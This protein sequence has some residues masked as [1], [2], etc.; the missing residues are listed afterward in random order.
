MSGIPGQEDLA[1]QAIPLWTEARLLQLLTERITAVND[2]PDNPSAHYALLTHVRTGAGFDQQEIDAITVD[3]WPAGG[4]PMT[5]YEVKCSRA[6]WL[7]E[8]HDRV[9]HT[10]TGG[11]YVR[12]GYAK[13]RRALQLVDAFVVLA[14]PG[15]VHH[16]DGEL[17]P[18]W[19]LLTPTTKGD[20]LRMTVTP[21]SLLTKADADRSTIPRSL[22]VSMLRAAGATPGW[23]RK[24][25]ASSPT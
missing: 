12:P 18:G 5:G 6:D 20:K 24:R 19:G 7:G 25:G 8:I 4:H 1:G 23:T 13:S 17:P 21:Q 14:A 3:L 16:N 22:L 2:R 9:I 10:R 11:S 15:I